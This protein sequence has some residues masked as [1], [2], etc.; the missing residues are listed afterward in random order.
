M[1]RKGEVITFHKVNLKTQRTGLEFL[2]M[3]S[4]YRKGRIS[5]IR[6]GLEQERM[7]VETSR[8]ITG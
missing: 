5:R 6:G 7:F 2:F 8:Q 3:Y 4:E 1:P